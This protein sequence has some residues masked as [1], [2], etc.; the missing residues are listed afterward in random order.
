M[1]RLVL[2]DAK[3]MIGLLAAVLLSSGA[4]VMAMNK[5]SFWLVLIIAAFIVLFTTVARTDKLM[6][7]DA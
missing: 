6:K 7:K 3:T 4:I 1:N 2:K 5:N